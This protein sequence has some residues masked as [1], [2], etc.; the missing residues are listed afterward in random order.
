MVSPS[1]SILQVIFYKDRDK[2]IPE[3]HHP[4]LES[5]DGR[6]GARH[7]P[8]GARACRADRDWGSPDT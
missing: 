7:I 4:G 2:H 6:C 8:G 5:V 3:T 1:I